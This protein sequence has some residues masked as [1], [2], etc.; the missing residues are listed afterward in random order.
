MIAPFALA[1]LLA[2]PQD[3]PI[4]RKGPHYTLV[5]HLPG[6]ALAD[7]ALAAAEAA[8]APAL[9][10]L[11][12]KEKKLS[13]PLV[14][15]LYPDAA[16]YEAAEAELTGGAFKANLSFSHFAT[17]SA[18]VA[19]Q[20]ACGTR[21]L[22]ELG[23]P[24]L[25]LYVIAHEAAHLASYAYVPNSVDHPEWFSEGMAMHVGHEALRTL[26]RAL[27]GDA[28]PLIGRNAVLRHELLKKDELPEAGL[29]LASEVGD[30]DFYARYAVN[31]GL[32]ELLLESHAK[33][34]DKT[35]KAIKKQG[36]GEG[37]RAGLLAEL[38]KIWSD[39]DLAKLQTEWLAA[40]GAG[41]P[42][43]D[44][45]L[46]SLES[47]D[48]GFVQRAS[49]RNAVAFR[50]QGIDVVPFTASGTVGTIA[51]DAHQMNFLL[52]RTEKGF[53]SVA[54]TFGQNVT[55]FRCDYGL[56][57]TWTI[58]G[59]APCADL[60]IG[61]DVPFRIDAS[62]EEIV[63]SIAGTEVVRAALKGR[64]PRGPWGLGAQAR[65]VGTWKDVSVV[66]AAK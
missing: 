4:E 30:L 64:S 45:V 31:L 33:D 58:L 25:T 19:L 22:I 51:G 28:E 24:T 14:I 1:L 3:G 62:A 37:Y 43:W 13:E 66:P 16:A 55:V 42:E 46:R 21:A 52:G 65:T 20:P 17:K 11:D 56:K 63:V 5:S 54:F 35:V 34:L 40:V 47:R 10:A 23:L 9:E 6:E 59:T 53:L 48:N 38:G 36:G 7:Q 18:H 8:W 26:K 44:E 27:P 15:H 39:K 2:V 60:K 12:L 57:D 50:T 61:T 32:Y 49:D 41:L 29:V